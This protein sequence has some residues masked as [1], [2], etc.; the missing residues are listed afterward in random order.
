MHRQARSPKSASP[1]PPAIQWAQN[2]PPSLLT[3]DKKFAAKPA[4]HPMGESA[5]PDPLAKAAR[6][7]MGEKFAAKPARHPMGEKCAAKPA[8]H[9]MG[10][11]H[12]V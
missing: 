4:S 7:P 11:N 2:A 3:K 6:H 1:S 10:E 12:A 8:R 5:P 9:P